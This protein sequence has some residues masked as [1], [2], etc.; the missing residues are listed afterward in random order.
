ML[1]DYLANDYVIHGHLINES[2]IALTVTLARMISMLCFV[3]AI[4]GG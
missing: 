4:T 1:T 3:F 2:R